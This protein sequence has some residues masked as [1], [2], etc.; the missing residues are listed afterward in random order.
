[1]GSA[2]GLLGGIPGSGAPGGTAVN[3][4]AGG[5]SRV[6]GVLCAGILLALVMGV[7][8][9]AGFIPVAALAGILLK[10][11]WDLIDW[12]LITRI[13]H[14]ERSYLLVM[15]LTLCLTVLT[16]SITAIAVGLIVAGFARALDTERLELA[17]VISVPLLERIFFST[18]VANDG[19][20][21]FLARVGMVRLLGRFSFASA[22]EL[23]TMVGADIAE[24]KVVIFDFSSTTGM[25]DSAA[26]VMER[27]I[28][29]AIATKT[30]CV[31]LNL[32][33]PVEKTLK[34]LN[35]LR[36]VPEGHFVA[37]LHEARDL[38]K[39]LLDEIN[40]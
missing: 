37:D 11:G 19:Q 18:G 9:V 30:E 32:S 8:G 38:A 33:G 28:D 6:S 7:G 25:D 5:S 39:S 23:V 29:T 31:V 10:V 2:A 24:H 17:R 22:N 34:S 35:V 36:R 21:D 13:R 12:R 4:R 20:D 14:I 3:I 1:M 27:L 40:G 26:L 16:D 15:L